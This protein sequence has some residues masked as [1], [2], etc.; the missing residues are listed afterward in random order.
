MDLDGISVAQI[1]EAVREKHV[2]NSEGMKV[3]QIFIAPFDQTESLKGTHL[4]AV[5]FPVLGKNFADCRVTDVH[6]DMN[7]VTSLSLLGHAAVK[8]SDHVVSQLITDFNECVN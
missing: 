1:A 7:D 6:V 2:T 8:Y 4:S 3:S 5:N